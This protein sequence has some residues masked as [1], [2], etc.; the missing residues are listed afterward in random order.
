MRGF[1]FR[2]HGGLDR[3]EFL[4]I[5]SP[6]PGSG[7]VRIRVKAAAF[8]AARQPSQPKKSSASA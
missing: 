7:E 8:R 6:I 5:P 4:D 3:L 2:E 1:G